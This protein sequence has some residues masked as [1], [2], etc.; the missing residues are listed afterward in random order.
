MF[1]RQNKYN[2][3]DISLFSGLMYIVGGIS[4]FFFGMNFF[5]SGVGNMVKKRKRLLTKLDAFGRFGY[6][7]GGV[8]TTAIIQS[9]DAT[10]I[11]AM[12]LSDENVID[13]SKALSLSFGARLG[14]TI[15][16][17]LATLSELNISTIFI[18][19]T[20]PM[21]LLFP[22]KRP[23][24]KSAL[25]GFGLFFSGLL[26]LKLGTAETES[27]IKMIFSH[28]GSNFLLFLLGLLVTAIF[29]SSSATSSVLV[30]LTSSG[31]IDIQSALFVYLGATIGT[32]V[33]PILVSIKLKDTAKFIAQAYSLSALVIGLISMV[34]FNFCIDQ[35]VLIITKIPNSLRL[36]TFGIFYSFISSILSLLLQ[37]PFEW[38]SG[39]IV[40]LISIKKYR[41][42]VN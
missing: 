40:D 35:A 42:P 4:L 24:V 8:F 39:K 41:K 28:T 22:K 11:L 3:V 37:K 17:L 30:I 38:V 23:N 21:A 27:Y 19:I 1:L 6:Y 10:T 12:N 20:L 32:T 34:V 5:S 36:A 9:S 16:A 18:G 15:T 2:I 7:L 31:V 26:L 25:L 33:T 14:T 13:K 29:Q